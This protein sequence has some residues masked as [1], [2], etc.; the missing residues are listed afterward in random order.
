MRD[1]TARAQ[2]TRRRPEARRAANGTYGRPVPAGRPAAAL[3]MASK[4]GH[5]CLSDV[6]GAEADIHS[7]DRR[8]VT[9]DRPSADQKKD[10]AEQMEQ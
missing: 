10:D 5:R 3:P 8:A 6:A 2:H 9:R 7:S 1:S 4:E